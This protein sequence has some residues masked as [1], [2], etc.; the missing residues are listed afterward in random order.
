[1]QLDMISYKFYSQIHLIDGSNL[2]SFSLH[3]CFPL[4]FLSS[5][6]LRSPFISVS[7]LAAVMYLKSI[8]IKSKKKLLIGVVLNL[9]D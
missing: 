5:S 3:L 2:P 7:P 6:I 9:K 1:M 4:T 8:V